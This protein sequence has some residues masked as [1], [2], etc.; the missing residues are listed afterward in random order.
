MP[1]RSLLGPSTACPVLSE[2]VCRYVHIFEHVPVAIAVIDPET[3]RYLEVN[4]R[5]CDRLG[6]T[7]EELLECSVPIINPRFQPTS[8]QE[9]ARQVEA[10]QVVQFYS[11]QTA[12]GGEGAQGPQLRRI[13]KGELVQGR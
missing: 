6:Y 13:G 8:M 5:F 10:H 7:R 4:Q 9:L 1:L 12:K 2:S 3:N 11:H